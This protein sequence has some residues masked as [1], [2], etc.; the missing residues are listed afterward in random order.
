[1]GNLSNPM[2]GTTLEAGLCPPPAPSASMSFSWLFLGGLVST[3]SRFRFTNRRQDAVHSISQSS[4]VQRTANTVLFD[5]L[6][7]GVHPKAITVVCGA[8]DPKTGEHAKGE[9]DK[10]SKPVTGD[11]IAQVGTI[12]ANNDETIGKI[13]AEAMK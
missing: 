13:I 3:R 6:S 4:I 10:L 9:L 8:I 2:L 7:G 5:C 12:S 11:M 1:M